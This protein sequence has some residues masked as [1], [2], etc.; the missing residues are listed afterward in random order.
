MNSSGMKILVPLDGTAESEAVLPW[1]EAFL[2]RPGTSVDLLHVSPGRSDEEEAPGDREASWVPHDCA[3]YLERVRERL[4]AWGG[5][6][7]G[8]SEVG[9]AAG[10]ILRAV[11]ASA[12]DL[13]LMR[14][15]SRQG[16]SRLLFGSTAAEVLRGSTVPLLVLGPA[17]PKPEAAPAPRGVLVPLDGSDWSARILADAARLARLF[18]ASMTLFHAGSGLPGL[19]GLAERLSGE[20]VPCAAAEGTGDPA[21]SILGRAGLPGGDVV[22]MATHGRSGLSKLILGSV[23]ERVV[24]ECPVPVLLRRPG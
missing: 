8:V 15:R 3:R 24:R 7:R 23:A 6:V 16:V 17:A 4:G 11:R 18:G 2:G 5:R 13:L 10:A 14:T 21:A 19:G 12:A 22:A 1:V 20:G 9:P